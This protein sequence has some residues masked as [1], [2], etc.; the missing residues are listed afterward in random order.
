MEDRLCTGIR[1]DKLIIKDIE[2]IGHC[3]ITEE[4]R[5]VGQRISADI[6]ISLDI[7][8]AAASDRLED[9]INYV[10]ICQRVVSTGKKEE[11]HLLEAL[12]NR[13]CEE[14][15]KNFKVSEV[16]LMLRKCSIPVDGIKGYFGVEV[17]RRRD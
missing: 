5:K 6:E 12:A 7:T 14:I 10:E 11:C 17:I 13:I 9:T 3:G 4:E 15:L 2:F 1:V 16:K 8:K